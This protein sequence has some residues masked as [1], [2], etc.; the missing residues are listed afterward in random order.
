MFP[1]NWLDTT[2]MKVLCGVIPEFCELGAA[3]VC[4]ED[5]NLDDPKRFTDYV[6]GHFPSGT[7]LKCL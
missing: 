5:P 6:G 2:A 1:A 7:S 4:D 3:L